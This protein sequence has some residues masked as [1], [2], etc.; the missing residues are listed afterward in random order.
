[1]I[2]NWQSWNGNATTQPNYTVTPSTKDAKQQ[3]YGVYSTVRLSITDPLKLIVGGRYSEYKA[4]NGT[5]SDV[6][7]D[8]FTPYVGVTYDI[9]PLVTAYASYT[10]IFSPT[11]NKD[12]NS[13]FL[14]P[15]TRKSL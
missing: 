5:K 7:A 8:S 3:N 15:E 4:T 9:T 10:D 11:T 14:D 12:R 1:L 2:N 13:R 6:K